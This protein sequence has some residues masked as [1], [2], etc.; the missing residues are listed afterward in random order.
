MDSDVLFEQQ[1]GP[2]YDGQMS[3]SQFCT[4][5]GATVN[6]QIPCENDR[7][8]PSYTD[9]SGHTTYWTCGLSRMTEQT[10]TELLQ[11]C[12][13]TFPGAFLVE[14][15][16][17]ADDQ[18]KVDHLTLVDPSAI[19]NPGT[20]IAVGARTVEDINF[21]WNGPGHPEDGQLCLEVRF[22]CWGK[23]E[24][25]FTHSDAHVAA[26][27]LQVS[28]FTPGGKF[29]G[30]P[31]GTEIKTSEF[32]ISTAFSANRTYLKETLEKLGNRLAAFRQSFLLQKVD[33]ATGE[34]LGEFR[35]DLDPDQH[36]WCR[37]GPNRWLDVVPERSNNRWVGIRPATAQSDLT[38]Q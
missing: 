34:I 18:Y 25:L 31:E 37:Q 23:A 33:V 7:D 32:R 3:L 36:E 13:D 20:Y 10:G 38:D 1:V 29:E 5:F 14:S 24:W 15:V 19:Q 30:A 9:F 28:V 12:L 27:E 26:K 22:D 16:L 11:T 6:G 21:N 17:D 8:A 4:H 2:P 35:Q